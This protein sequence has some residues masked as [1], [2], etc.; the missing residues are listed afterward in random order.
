M[1]RALIAAASYEGGRV[2]DGNGLKFLPLPPG[3]GRGEGR[4]ICPPAL[5]LTRSNR[6]Q[7]QGTTST[8]NLTQRRHKRFTA[9]SARDVSCDY[10]LRPA[11]WLA[12]PAGGRVSTRAGQA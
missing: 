8:K 1:A 10:I 11:A 6:P 3:E 7:E 5:T 9:V 12:A 2:Y 4:A